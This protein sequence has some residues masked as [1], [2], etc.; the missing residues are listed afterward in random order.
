MRSWVT[1]WAFT[2][3]FKVS[4]D[5]T[6][7]AFFVDCW[8]FGSC[9]ICPWA[10]TEEALRVI[11]LCGLNRFW[12][13]TFKD[14]LLSGLHLA[15][16]LCTS[17]WSRADAFSVLLAMAGLRGSI[18]LLV[19]SSAVQI[20]MAFYKVKS[21]TM[22]MHHLYVVMEFTPETMTSCNNLSESDRYLHSC[23]ISCAVFMNSDRLRLPCL[24]SLSYMKLAISF[25]LDCTTLL[26]LW[27]FLYNL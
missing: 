21:I 18:C 23:T 9:F 25:C 5:F 13:L 27:R 6:V 1:L 7:V 2:D 8:T 26:V 3:S 10:S 22:S 19:E 24:R 15:L 20:L 4:Y 11:R 12:V 14:V 16:N 17:F